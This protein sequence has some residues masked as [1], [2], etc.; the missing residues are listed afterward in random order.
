MA[1]SIVRVD[2]QNRIFEPLPMVPLPRWE[3]EIKD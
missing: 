2:N 3:V 1:P